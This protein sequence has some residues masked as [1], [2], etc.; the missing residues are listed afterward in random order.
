[1]P[2]VEPWTVGARGRTAAGKSS[3]AQYAQ[4]YSSSDLGV[5][6]T[7]LKEGTGGFARCFRDWLKDNQPLCAYTDS[8]LLG[9]AGDT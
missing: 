3:G 9:W 5:G 6:Y 7:V 4:Q 1:M 8:D 2:P